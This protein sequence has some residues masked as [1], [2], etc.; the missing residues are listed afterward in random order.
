MR[1]DGWGLIL[2]GKKHRAH[3]Q[4]V[5]NEIIPSDWR[6]KKGEGHERKDDEGDAFLKNLQLRHAPFV[7]ANAIR[8]NLKDVFEK[9]DAPA[10]QDHNP[11]S[12]IPEF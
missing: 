9:R 12:L 3:D 8:R 10:N 1:S 11:E 4:Q 6:T 5:G 7:G 2:E